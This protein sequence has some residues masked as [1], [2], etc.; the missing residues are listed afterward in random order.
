M[1]APVSPATPASPVASAPSAPNAATRPED[2]VPVPSKVAYGAANMVG[3]FNGNLTKELINPVYV[4]ALGLSPALVGVAMMIFRLYDAFTDPIMGW[5]SDNTRTRWGRRRPWML[6]GCILCAFSLYLMW[7]VDRDWSTGLQTAWLIGAGIVL[8]TCS[9]IWGVPYESLGLE[10]TPDY[11]ERTSVSS[12]KM[13]ISSAAGLLIGWAWTITQL[14]MFRDPVTGAPDTL[15]G[16][17]GLAILAG[18]LIILFGTLSVVVTRERFYHAAKSQEKVTLKG[19]FAATLR[20]RPFLALVFVALCAVTATGLVNGIG[21]FVRLYHVCGGDTV[22]AAK[23]TGYQAT[24][25]LPISIVAVFL[26]QAIGGRWSKTHA[27][28][29]AMVFTTV[30]AVSQWWLF[31]PD[32]PYLS[33]VPSFLLAFG[34]TGMWQMLPSMNA[35]VVDDDELHTHAR[36]EGAFAAIFSWF[37][38]LS[39]T[40]GVGLPGVIVTWAGFAV[41]NGKSQLP[42]VITSMR[43]WHIGLPLGLLLVSLILLLSYPLSVGRMTQIR[44][45]LEARRGNL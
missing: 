9:T 29:V 8:Y 26:F 13:I 30:A 27:L 25:W 16:A 11:K 4:I 32:L 22:L 36:R 2:R 40:V 14:P 37:M 20:S 38:K 17:R 7:M 35:D 10:L 45:E 1:S 6:L 23:I 44:R 19:N 3:L 42:G 34:T 28:I 15:A 24:F 41:A 33:L 18:A 39:F 31:R 21:F 12:Y 43:L 5:I